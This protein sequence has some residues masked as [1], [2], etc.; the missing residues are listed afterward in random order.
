VNN[1][2]THPE[3]Q[4]ALD[5]LKEELS[6]MDIIHA[7]EQDTENPDLWE[8]AA[9]DYWGYANVGMVGWD[10]D[11]ECVIFIGLNPCTV[12]HDLAEDV[13]DEDSKPWTIFPDADTMMLFL[14]GSVRTI[15]N[16][17]RTISL[18]NA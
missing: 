15:M 9:C 11:R 16:K 7:F 8:V 3:V 4:A 13:A 6:S 12:A 17:H 2:P 18:Q 5:F 10:V 14:D 1:L